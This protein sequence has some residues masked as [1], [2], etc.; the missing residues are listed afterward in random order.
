[1]LAGGANAPGATVC[2]EVIFVLGSASCASCSQLWPAARALG[3]NA[4]LYGLSA[5]GFREPERA[6]VVLAGSGAAR[7]FEGDL[8]RLSVALTERSM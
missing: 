8:F 7:F 1:M 4:L 5:L 2:A 3:T 6:I